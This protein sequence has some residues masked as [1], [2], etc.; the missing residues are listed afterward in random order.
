[1]VHWDSPVL[2]SV[3]RLS[4]EKR[5]VLLRKEPKIVSATV[6]LRVPAGCFQTH[7]PLEATAL[8]VID[9]Q[10]YAIHASLYGCS[11]RVCEDVYWTIGTPISSQCGQD[12]FFRPD[13][14]TDKLAAT[15]HFRPWT[16]FFK[17][18]SAIGGMHICCG[19]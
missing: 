9:N 6:T 2:A 18:G 4:E 12:T 1:M 13:E 3:L 11:G 5:N 10:V 8:N 17:R 16:E 7:K 15:N 14:R 19:E